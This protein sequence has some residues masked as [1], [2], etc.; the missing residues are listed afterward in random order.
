MGEE[1]FDIRIAFGLFM[2]GELDAVVIGRCLP[3]PYGK[4]FESSHA[5]SMDG[6]CRRV[7]DLVRTGI[8]ALALDVREKALRLFLSDDRIAFPMA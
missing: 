2:L 8:T 3:F 1:Y 6:V 5:C 7:F 4:P